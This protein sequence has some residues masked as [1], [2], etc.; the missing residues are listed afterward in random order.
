MARLAAHLGCSPNEL[1]DLDLELFTQTA[2]AVTERLKA[3]AWS[4]DTELLAV[5]AEQ[6]N[7]VFI[8]TVS[9]NSKNKPNLKPLEIPRPHRPQEKAPAVS[10]RDAALMTGG[11][12]V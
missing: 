8:A 7:A 6:V 2:K 9:A 5:I 10:P 11:A 1:L 4:Q 12:I 3:E